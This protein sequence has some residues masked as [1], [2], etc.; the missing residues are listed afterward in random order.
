VIYVRVNADSNAILLSDENGKGGGN[1]F[2]AQGRKV[3]WINDASFTDASGTVRYFSC[4]LAF[5]ELFPDTND[6]YGGP[7][8]PFHPEQDPDP[9]NC[10]VSIAAK[11]PE[12]AT[13]NWSG[14]LK[15]VDA[16]KY[17]KYDVELIPTNGAPKPPT[18]DPILIIED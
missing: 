17:Y 10:T 5:K 1:V 4:K 18:L 11:T 14:H 7:R 9:P 12:G 6:E 13:S 3:T 15:K 2:G 16:L 8:W